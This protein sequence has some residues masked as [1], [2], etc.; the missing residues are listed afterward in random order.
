MMDEKNKADGAV[1]QLIYDGG[2]K[3][4]LICTGKELNNL[5]D[6]ILNQFGV[7]I[8]SQKEEGAI[9]PQ[10]ADTDRQTEVTATSQH[11]S[12]PDRQRDLYT[13][14]MKL[15]DLRTRGVI[16]DEEFAALKKKRLDEYQ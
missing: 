13:E 3:L 8:A 9:N 2:K 6:N 5:K 7:S 10:E 16:S 4:D 14:L 1:V 12:N 15:D 11:E